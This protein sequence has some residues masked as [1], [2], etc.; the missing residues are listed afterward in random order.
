MFLCL[1]VPHSHGMERTGRGISCSSPFRFGVHKKPAL[2]KSQ[3]AGRSCQN[4]D[5]VRSWQAAAARC[6]PSGG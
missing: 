6:H 2:Q 3:K 5:A 1:C 4:M